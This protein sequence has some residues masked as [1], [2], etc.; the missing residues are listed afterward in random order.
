MKKSNI[1]KSSTV[2]SN[3]LLFLA[4]ILSVLLIVTSSQPMPSSLSLAAF[5]SHGGGDYQGDPSISD[6]AKEGNNNNQVGGEEY[7]SSLISNMISQQ[8]SPQADARNFNADNKVIIVEDCDDSE[9]VIKDNDQII[10]TNTQSFNQ[11]ANNQVGEEEE[12]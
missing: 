1:V 9:I 6:T 5:A 10:Q 7:G 11:E 12:E 2:S 4:T 8:Q 3:F